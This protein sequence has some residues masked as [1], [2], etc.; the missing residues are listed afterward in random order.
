MDIDKLSPKEFQDLLDKVPDDVKPVFA[1][2]Y[3]KS[4]DNQPIKDIQNWVKNYDY[5]CAVDNLL[6]VA[7]HEFIFTAG[8]EIH[9]DI[10]QKKEEGQDDYFG[11]LAVN[12]ARKCLLKIADRMKAASDAYNKDKH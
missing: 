8:Y 6:S 12:I 7:M 1:E 11:G 5:T 3:F 10:K 2:L 9:E 4:I